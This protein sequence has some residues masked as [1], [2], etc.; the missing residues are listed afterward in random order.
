[1]LA[2]GIR[3]SP[4]SITFVQRLLLDERWRP[5]LVTLEL[6]FGTANE[7]YMHQN[8]FLVSIVNHQPS[9]RALNY[10][11]LNGS[12][13]FDWSIFGRL[14]HIRYQ[15]DEEGNLIAGDRIRKPQTKRINLLFFL[16]P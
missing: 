6:C 2:L 3:I 8:D 5:H 4:F 14:E 13:K 12:A 10:H 11:Y 1:H 7:Y 9:L 16:L 15:S